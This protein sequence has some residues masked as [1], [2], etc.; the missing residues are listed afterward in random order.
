IVARRASRL[1]GALLASLVQQQG[2]TGVSVAVGGVLFDVNPG[3]YADAVE[4]MGVLGGAGSSV[5]LQGRGADLVGAAV[6]AASL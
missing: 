6:N 4:T 3:I 2:S 5:V 1:A